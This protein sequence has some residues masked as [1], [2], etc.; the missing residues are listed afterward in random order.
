[1]INGCAY[2]TT[3]LVIHTLT[4]TKQRFI[5][6]H[7]KVCTGMAR[8]RCTKPLCLPMK[9]THVKQINKNQ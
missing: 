3:I 4:N 7:K 9:L 1:M 6:L 8:K 2:K 5:D